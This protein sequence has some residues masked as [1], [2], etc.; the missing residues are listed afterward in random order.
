[1]YYHVITI[2]GYC[3]KSGSLLNQRPIKYKLFARDMK[4][5][6]FIKLEISN[7][8]G[9]CFSLH[10]KQHSYSYVLQISFV[11]KKSDVR[12]LEHDLKYCLGHV[13]PEPLSIRRQSLVQSGAP[14]RGGV[15]GSQPPPHEFWM[16]G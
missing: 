3:R 11:Q 15:G 7:I 10:I 8:I 6:H 2:K 4:L 12:I 9:S 13:K 14:N 5:L 16:E 1:M